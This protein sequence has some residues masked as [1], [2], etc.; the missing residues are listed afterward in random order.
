MG[1]ISK[2]KR[3]LIEEAN[4]RNLGLIKEEA[5]LTEGLF[6]FFKKFSSKNEDIKDELSSK[7]G[8]EDG[9]TKEEI[10]EKLESKFGI[11]DGVSFK[12][13]A[14]NIGGALGDFLILIISIYLTYK[15]VIASPLSNEG[16][17]LEFLAY[18]IA[19]YLSWTLMDSMENKQ[20]DERKRD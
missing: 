14:K 12:E 17:I 6:R 4:K 8:I 2:I 18:G 1:R 20:E 19:S 7:L 10:E 9:D 16:S 15:A 11:V 3:Q 13:M 5:L